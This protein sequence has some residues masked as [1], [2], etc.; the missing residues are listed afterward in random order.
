M[1]RRRDASLK[2]IT[3]PL[4]Q[5]CVR[6][7]VPCHVCGWRPIEITG[8]KLIECP[9]CHIKIDLHPQLIRPYGKRK[10]VE[11]PLEDTIVHDWN[12]TM[13]LLETA[14]RER[15]NKCHTEGAAAIND[16]DYEYTGI[17][18]EASFN[19]DTKQQ[20][21]YDTFMEQSGKR[22]LGYGNKWN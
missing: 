22:R 20:D 6:R 3:Q 13:D 9:G 15:S 16:S 8:T 4:S 18:D 21:H 14:V 10:L 12:K 5:A 11:E 19:F 1:A 7:L 2:E 17:P